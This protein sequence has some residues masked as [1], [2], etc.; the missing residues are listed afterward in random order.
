MGLSLLLGSAGDAGWWWCVWVGGVRC[1]GCNVIGSA[2]AGW[3]WRASLSQCV[4]GCS[5]RCGVQVQLPSYVDFYKTGAFKEMPPQDSDWYYTRA[6]VWVG[7]LLDGGGLSLPWDWRP[8]WGR[9][10]M[11]GWR[12]GGAFLGVARGAL[13]EIAGGASQRGLSPVSRCVLLCAPRC[14]AAVARR[15]Y[16][17]KG[18]GVGEFRRIFGGRSFKKGKVAPEHFARGAGGVVRH[19]LQQLEALGLVEKSAGRKGGR[20]I[21]A[22]G[23][24]QL[25]L[26]AGSV[27]A[28]RAAAVEA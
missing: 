1:T 10:G 28:A 27:V 12:P 25:D 17:Q 6:G 26:V 16:I 4:F 14:A 23:Q 22:E 2:R 15:V 19:A 11:G 8:G 21:T 13:L 24:R 7:R 18:L 3:W 20:A 9:L 5:L